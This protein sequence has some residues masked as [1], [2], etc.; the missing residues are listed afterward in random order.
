[1]PALVG[2]SEYPASA[3]GY[4]RQASRPFSLGALLPKSPFSRASVLRL[5]AASALAAAISCGGSGGSVSDIPAGGTSPAGTP[6]PAPTPGA[7]KLDGLSA[8]STVA[9]QVSLSASV[10]AGTAKVDFQVDGATVATV[11][12]APFAT[13]WDSFSVANGSHT[14]AVRATDSAGTAKAGDAVPVS[15][16][17]R[18]GH[19]FVILLENHDWSQI[20]G[21][22][23]APYI[24]GTLLAQ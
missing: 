9:G 6:A 19:V 17:N 1:M 4:P 14:I 11:P 16:D 3:R 13:T 18:I 10:P 15:V 12:A 20:K 22:A 5:L 8:G 24:N 23:S 2:R 21:N 7:P